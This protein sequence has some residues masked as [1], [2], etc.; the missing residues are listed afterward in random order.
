MKTEIPDQGRILIILGPM[1][2]SGVGHA[3]RTSEKIHFDCFPP[4]GKSFFKSTPLPF[5]SL[6]FLKT[7]TSAKCGPD[8]SLETIVHTSRREKVTHLLFCP[9][10]LTL[11]DEV[12]QQL[13]GEPFDVDNDMLILLPKDS[14]APENSCSWW[15]AINAGPLLSRF[16]CGVE[17]PPPPIEKSL[18]MYPLKAFFDEKGK[19]ITIADEYEF[20][21]RSTWAG[22]NPFIRYT[23]ADNN[24]RN[25]G[26]EIQDVTD[27]RKIHYMKWSYLALRH[28]LPWPLKKRFDPD[29]FPL[30]INLFHPLRTLLQ[31][32]RRV[33]RKLESGEEKLSLRHPIRSLKML[34]V[35]KMSPREVAY[36]AMLGF[37]L[38][39]LPLIGLHTVAVIFYA[40]RFRL[41]R[42]IAFYASGIYA[43]FLPPFL[44]ALEIELGYYFCHGRFLTFKDIDTHAELFQKLGLEAHL[45]LWEYF[46]GSLVFGPVL[47]GVLGFIVYRIACSF[48][49]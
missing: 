23:D 2:S 33:Y 11:D 4:N 7:A 42:A 8:C 32:H 34:H 29:P 25:S 47:A 18:R 41:N 15:S 39:A 3:A 46:L 20:I 9:I 22:L 6:E 21:I 19:V 13:L 12:L 28:C 45:R 5:S 49:K 37:F 24:F 16:A 14:R 1:Q 40:T 17:L 26:Q 36:A 44:P 48:Q 38:G 31:L 43:P 27:T 30:E 10:G 35:E